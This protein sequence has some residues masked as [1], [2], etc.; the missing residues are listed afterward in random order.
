MKRLGILIVLVAFVAVL[1]IL[2]ANFWTSESKSKTEEIDS[3]NEADKAE[4]KATED[5]TTPAN[6]QEKGDVE[7]Q[8]KTNLIE[9][10]IAHMTL[11]EKIGQLIIAGLDGTEITEETKGLI[12]TNHV[13]G[14]IFFK[15]N[16]A[17]PEQARQLVNDVK[18]YNADRD[19]PLFFAIDQEGGRVTRL[20]GLDTMKTNADIAAYNDPMFSYET[21]KVLAAQLHAFGFQVNF[22]P[23]VD[24]NS[25]PNNPVI[26]DRAFGSNPEV[27][28]EYGVQMMKGMQSEN[29]ITSIKHFPGHGD[30]NEDSH[31][32]LPM[33]DKDLSALR[34]MELIPFAAAMEEGA[35]MVMIAHILL[36]E[37][38]TT[39]P[40][41][42]SP[43]VVT[44]LLREEMGYDGVV[45]TDDMTMGAIVNHY[46]LGEASIQAVKAGVDIILMAHGDEN[47]QTT[48]SAL[49]QAVEEGDISEERID[50]SVER[51]LLL[52]DQYELTDEPIESI[53]IE[54]LNEEIRQLYER[55]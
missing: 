40:A 32:E 43:E 7:A 23:S 27:V 18:E 54:K 42:L 28:S 45:V 25:N 1:L 41:T 6:K 22:A 5:A 10:T 35:D 48:F 4:K 20:P 15:P 19:I 37:L 36:P 31:E 29:I 14:F 13:G 55:Y 24:V 53:D 33:I 26:G 9:N 21:G 38:A 49:K 46:G 52:K 17:S 34:E 2:R 12:D 30:T 47:V 39:Y 11:D 8:T 3:S 16:L 44:G 51:I 50:K